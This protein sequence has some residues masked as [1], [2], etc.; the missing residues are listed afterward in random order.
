MLQYV[1]GNHF[2][3]SGISPMKIGFLACAGTI[4]GSPRRR[5]DAHEHDLQVDALEPALAAHGHE[6]VVIDWRAPLA[7]FDGIPLILLGTVWDYQDNEADFLAKL[8]ALEAAGIDICNSS[9]TLRWNIDKRYLAEL[10]DMGAATIPTLWVENP[11]ASDISRA[12]DHF[13]TASVVVKRQV[14]AGAEGQSIFHQKD[15]LDPQW[16]MHRAAMIQP[17]QPAIQSEGEYSFVFIDGEFSHSTLKRAAS[18]DYRIQSLY[19]GTELKVDPTQDDRNSAGRIVDLLPLPTPLYARIDM[20]RDDDGQLLL[21]EAE[22][23]EPYLY[24]EQGPEL[25]PRIAAGIERRLK[26]K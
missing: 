13:K 16:A 23:I 5:A 20:V 26:M 10:A 9:E 14:G 19:G 15:A 4:P 12:F 21:M 17:F 1:E 3:E 24:P 22:L 11:M 6:L 25:G 7:E 2:N 18:G 8:D